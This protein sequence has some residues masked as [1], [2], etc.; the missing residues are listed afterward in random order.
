VLDRQAE[1][2]RRLLLRTS[3]LERVNRE[4]ADL[5]T[6]DRGGERTLQDLER[7]GAFVVSLDAARTWFR[8]HHLFAD[9]LQLE[10]RRTEPDEVAGLHQ[11]PAGWF[12]EH[13]QP[14]EAI[15]HTQAAGDWE[16]Q[17]REGAQPSRGAHRGKLTVGMSPLVVA[18]RTH[19]DRHGDLVTQDSRR[20]VGGLDAG[21]H[22]GTEQGPFECLAVVTKCQFVLRTF[23][24]R[25]VQSAG[26]PTARLAGAP[27][28]W[29][30]T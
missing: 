22:P 2:V 4:L 7:A 30:L 18:G 29:L 25:S 19:H 10:L 21:E 15:R 8:Y 23:A 17:D 6:G 9:L 5:L 14:V 27:W 24:K 11:A 12:A 26:R 16:T 1:P 13:G 3:I 20:Q 28:M